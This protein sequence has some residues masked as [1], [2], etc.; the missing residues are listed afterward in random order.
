MGF[1]AKKII[2][3]K[4]LSN[5]D[6]ILGSKI[7]LLSFILGVGGKLVYIEGMVLSNHQPVMLLSFPSLPVWKP[8]PKGF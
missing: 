7:D 6:L 3:P 8:P 4:K 1:L 2:T 5:V